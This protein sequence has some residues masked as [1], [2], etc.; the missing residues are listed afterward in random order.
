[1]NRQC[2][3]WKHA[4]VTAQCAI[5]WQVKLVHFVWSMNCLLSLRGN[6]HPLPGIQVPSFCLVFPHPSVVAQTPPSMFY[7]S[8][9]ASFFQCVTFEACFF[10]CLLLQVNSQLL[11]GI[12]EDELLPQALSWLCHCASPL[13]WHF[14]QS[15]ILGILRKDTISFCFWMVLL[16]PQAWSQD[17]PAAFPGS[18]SFNTSQGGS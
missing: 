7:T 11:L 13:C 2:Y 3:S 12:C 15:C 17:I 6:L 5:S 18:S 8:E 10:V 1:M 4:A 16:N 9:K 14:C